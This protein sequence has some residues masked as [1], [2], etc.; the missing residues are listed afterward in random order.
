MDIKEITKALNTEFRP[1]DPEHFRLGVWHDGTTL[2]NSSIK[3]SRDLDDPTKTFIDILDKKGTGKGDVSD[4]NKLKKKFNELR[5]NLPPGDYELN[6]DHPTKAKKYIRD[7][8]KQPGFKLS[9][10]KGGAKVLNKKTGKLE[11]KSFD[12]LTMNVPK[13]RK[14]GSRTTG[15]QKTQKR[16]ADLL[17]EIDDNIKANELGIDKADALE[18]RGTELKRDADGVWRITEAQKPQ[19]KELMRAYKERYQKDPSI[20]KFGK[21]E[22]DGKPFAIRGFQK[23]TDPIHFGDITKERATKQRRLDRERVPKND[24][25]KFAKSLGDPPSIIKEYLQE[26]VLGAKS[27]QDEARALTASKKVKHEGGHYVGLTT[28]IPGQPGAVPPTTRRN[29]RPELK[30]ENRGRGVKGG[31]QKT[32]HLKLPIP[33]TWKEDYLFWREKK[34]GLKGLT[35]F[36][37]EFNPEEQK[38]LTDINPRAKRGTVDDILTEIYQERD[39]LKGT[40]QLQQEEIIRDI[41][42]DQKVNKNV[43]KIQGEELENARQRGL[44]I[45]AG[46]ALALDRRMNLIDRGLDLVDAIGTRNWQQGASAIAPMTSMLGR[47]F[48]QGQTGS[49]LE[50]HPVVQQGFAQTQDPFKASAEARAQPGKLQVLGKTIPD[51][52][53][54]EFFAPPRKDRFDMFNNDDPGDD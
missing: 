35:D 40:G 24:I 33:K 38:R 43:L 32:T 15:N 23:A 44:K 1:G 45:N 11:H 42:R 13:E 28:K 37:E 9:G 7:F 34:F 10:E 4:I 29:M 49:A 14:P 27:V 20:P 36:K 25:T 30:S 39:R 8:L 53:V 50:T 2:D 6:A 16:L 22:I 5:K 19:L 26:T 54:S 51:L 48:M 31:S 21:I 47:A 52:G 46:N 41:K 3:I 18:V 12:T 17:V